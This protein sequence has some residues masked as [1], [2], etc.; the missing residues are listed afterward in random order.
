MLDTPS[1]KLSNHKEKTIDVL[2]SVIYLYLPS[3]YVER[4][5]RKRKRKRMRS[6]GLPIRKDVF[7]RI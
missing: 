2:Y 3:K 1:Q 7:Y 5:I 6:V 4:G